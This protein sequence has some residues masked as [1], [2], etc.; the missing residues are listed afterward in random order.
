MAQTDDLELRDE[1]VY[2]D[3]TVLK[4]VLGRAFA[5]YQSLLKL[6]EAHALTYEW[7]Y[8]RDGKAWLCKVQKKK[9]TIIWMSARTGYIKA[10]IYVPEKFLDDLLKLDIHQDTKERIKRSKTILKS[11][12]CEFDIKTKAVLQD[13]ETVM[14]FKVNLT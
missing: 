6:F 8:Y 14:K 3:E 11:R 1:R 4:R 5:A 12:P 7:R 10:G 9:K 13:L 2:P